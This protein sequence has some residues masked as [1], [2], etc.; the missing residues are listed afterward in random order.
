MAQIYDRDT[1]IAY[2]EQIKS[3]KMTVMEVVKELGCSKT[4][5]YYWI[6]QLEEDS[7]H[8]LPGSGRMKPDLEYQRRLEKENRQLKNEVEFLKKAAAYFAGDQRKGTQ[9]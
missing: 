4:A 3:A 9:R 8:G 2:V 7:E 6:R 5:V 1:K